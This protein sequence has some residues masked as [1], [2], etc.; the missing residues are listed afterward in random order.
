MPQ[1]LGDT[2][3]ATLYC[4]PHTEVV[5]SSAEQYARQF[6]AMVGPIRSIRNVTSH[7]IDDTGVARFYQLEVRY[8]MVRSAYNAIKALNGVRLDVSTKEDG[9]IS[10]HSFFFRFFVSVSPFSLTFYEQKC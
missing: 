3:F 9:S 10:F 6:L 8:H 2:V 4:G 1:D 5:S 7:V